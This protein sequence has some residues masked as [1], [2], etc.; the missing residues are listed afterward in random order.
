M[1][2]LFHYNIY[3]KNQN[4]TYY[5]EV[6]NIIEINETLF[7]SLKLLVFIEN[8]IKENITYLIKIIKFSL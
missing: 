7:T 4:I 8:Q 5:I 3:K 6:F 1:K 2:I